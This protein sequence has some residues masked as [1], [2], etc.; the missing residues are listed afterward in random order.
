V[1]WENSKASTP[2]KRDFL[3]AWFSEDDRFFLTGGSALGLFY[4]H[5]RRSY[6]L[7]LFT[8]L[9]SIDGQTLRNQV[10]RLAHRIGAECDPMQTTPDFLRF[11]LRRGEDREV[12]DFVVD[13][14]PQLEV[15]KC[16]QGTIRVDTLREITANKWAALL[17]R[18]EV[19]DLVD[20][21]F[22]ERAG[23]D[24]FSGFEDAR[25]KDAG[26]DEAVLSQLL[27]ALRIRTL[28]DFLLEPLTIDELRSFADR[29]RRELA[30]RAFPPEPD[31]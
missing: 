5:H 30:L 23:Y 17:G 22:I 25:Q 26:M 10:I 28:P 8:T 16:Q 3:T 11:E 21:Y 13:R 20:L 24:L 6:D 2:L 29:L 12:I 1:N 31:A 7:D 19:K 27:A 14:V 9:E 15:E 18:S 4:L